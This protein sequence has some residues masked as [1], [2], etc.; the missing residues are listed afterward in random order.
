MDCAVDTGK[1]GEHYFV[2]TPTWLAAVGS[3]RGM[4]CVGCLEKRLGR[5]LNGDDFTSATI[6][7][8]LHEIKSARLMSRMRAKN[9]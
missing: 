5:K 1:I 9:T 6:N 8:P 7:S 3:I 4:L 2:H